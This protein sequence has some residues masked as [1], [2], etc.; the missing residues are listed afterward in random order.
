MG[1][2]DGSSC[3]GIDALVNQVKIL[4]QQQ[5]FSNGRM[6]AR[7]GLGL[8]AGLVEAPFRIHGRYL[9]TTAKHVDDRPLVSVVRIVFLR[10][11]PADQRIRAERHLVA[12]SH[13]FFRLLVKGCAE[14]PDNH[15]GNAKMN[16]VS[17]IS[18]RIAMPKMQHG[19]CLSL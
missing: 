5:V 2:Y 16:D 8:L 7:H 19:R 12:V 15:D 18:A 4:D 14:D 6:N 3:V 17:A 1:F 11:R 10:I 9:L 13:L